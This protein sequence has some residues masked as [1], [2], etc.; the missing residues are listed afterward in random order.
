VCLLVCLSTEMSRDWR[1]TSN[2]PE[3]AWRGHEEQELGLATLLAM[4][5]C[6]TITILL[7]KAKCLYEACEPTLD[8]I[9]F[10]L[11]ERM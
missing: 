3:T 9:S 6:W 8:A 1:E 4:T 10:Q 11:E 7:S 2:E 5:F